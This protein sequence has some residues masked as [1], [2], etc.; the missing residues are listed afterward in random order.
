M[1]DTTTEVAGTQAAPARQEARAGV[2]PACSERDP[3][4][5]AIL[6]EWF[7]ALPPAPYRDPFYHSLEQVTLTGIEATLRAKYSR[8]R[9][10]AR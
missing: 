7:G 8:G 9:R 3:D 10:R 6:R 1:N 5:D 2:A 4:P